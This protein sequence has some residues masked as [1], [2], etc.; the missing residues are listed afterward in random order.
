[1]EHKCWVDVEV[2]S[3]QIG[4][5]ELFLVGIDIIDIGRYRYR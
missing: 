1:M 3:S 4:V 5:F 2:I